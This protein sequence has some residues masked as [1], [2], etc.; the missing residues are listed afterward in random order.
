MAQFPYE[1][2]LYTVTTSTTYDPPRRVR[3]ENRK[4]AAAIIADRIARRRYGSKGYCHHVR[5]DCHTMDGRQDAYEAFVGYSV[6]G[7]SCEGVNI[8]VYVS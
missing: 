8:W 7:S 1:R 5:F 2:Q 3:A 4:D 6:Q